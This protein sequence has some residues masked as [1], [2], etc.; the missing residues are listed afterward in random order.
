[1]GRRKREA[2]ERSKRLTPKKSGFSGM[3]RPDLE[4]IRT[5]GHFRTEADKP[6]NPGMTVEQFREKLDAFAR[7]AITGRNPQPQIRINVE[8]MEDDGHAWLNGDVDL[9]FDEGDESAELQAE[10]AAAALQRAV[11]S[12]PHIGGD[13]VGYGDGLIGISVT[14]AL[15]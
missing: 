5:G 8:R 2:K 14:V 3:S 1:M 15:D 7:A 12:D 11:D 9:L 6:P 4:G 10:Q 13:E